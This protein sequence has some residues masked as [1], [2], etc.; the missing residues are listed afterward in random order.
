MN[1]EEKEIPTKPLQVFDFELSGKVH[2]FDISVIKEPIKQDET[3]RSLRD[4]KVTTSEEYIDVTIKDLEN[5]QKAF[6]YY[7]SSLFQCPKRCLEIKSKSIENLS[8]IIYYDLFEEEWQIRFKY[9]DFHI[10]HPLPIVSSKIPIY[11]DDST[12]DGKLSKYL[13]NSDRLKDIL[14]SKKDTEKII[15][16]IQFT[17]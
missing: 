9:Q 11:K 4:Y 14:K 6:E 3:L 13:L 17:A 5:I 1:S 2:S 8:C 7:I 12:R 15:Q 10:P 16:E